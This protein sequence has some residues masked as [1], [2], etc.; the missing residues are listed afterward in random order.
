MSENVAN[1][2]ISS[3]SPAEVLKVVLDE[4]QNKIEVVVPKEHLSLAIG[5][6][7][8]NVK[9]ATE[10]NGYEIDILTEDEE[11]SKRQEDFANKTETFVSSLDVDETLAQL[12]VSEGFGNIEEVLEADESELLSIEGFDEEIVSELIERSKKYLADQENKNQ[13]KI[14]SLKVQKD[15]I[16]FNLLSK[17]MIVKLAENNIKNLEDFAG[18]TTDDL[19][20]YFEDK[21]D[22]NSRVVGLLEEF[23]V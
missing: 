20:G 18:L 10:L 21:S 3:L 22:K 12:L 13:E 17:A 16:E 7:G 19:I 14:E 1:L 4:D 2:A 5:R 15:L 23:N 11:S 8:Q 9:L 6:R